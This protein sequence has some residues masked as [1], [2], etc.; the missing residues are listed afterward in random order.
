MTKNVLLEATAKPDIRDLPTVRG[1]CRDMLPIH[2]REL[3]RGIVESIK[4]QLG[5]K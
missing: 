4:K 5:L 2:S 3:K 1:S